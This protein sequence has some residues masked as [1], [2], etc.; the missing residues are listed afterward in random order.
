VTPATLSCDLGHSNSVVRPRPDAAPDR[1]YIQTR[2]RQ[3]P[4]LVTRSI[5]GKFQDLHVECW[6]ERQNLAQRVE[7]EAHEIRFSGRPWSPPVRTAAGRIQLTPCRTSSSLLIRRNPSQRSTDCRQH[8]MPTLS[9]SGWVHT[10]I[11]RERSLANRTKRE[12]R[13]SRTTGCRDGGECRA[14]DSVVPRCTKAPEHLQQLTLK[15]EGQNLIP[16]PVATYSLRFSVS[17][18]MHGD[19]LPSSYLIRRTKQ[20]NE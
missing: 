15:I 3:E 19:R 16:D 8:R 9:V 18:Q 11:C 2:K 10:A 20:K 6:T 4:L 1:D 5:G 17:T 7:R 12:L 14:D 13:A